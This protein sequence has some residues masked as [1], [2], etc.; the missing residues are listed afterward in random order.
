MGYFDEL[1]EEFADTF[2]EF[3]G[4]DEEIEIETPA[5]KKKFPGVFGG[6]RRETVQSINGG[7]EST[8]ERDVCQGLVQCPPGTIQVNTRMTLFKHTTG[9]QSTF[10]QQSFYVRSVDGS[11]HGMTTCTVWREQLSKLQSRGL[12]GNS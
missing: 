1:A 9:D 3:L 5:G 6:L 8:S 2:V 10:G 4:D 12:E 7:L 11:D